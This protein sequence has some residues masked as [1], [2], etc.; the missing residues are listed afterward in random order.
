MGGGQDADVMLREGADLAEGRVHAGAGDLGAVGGRGVQ[1]RAE[2]LRGLRGVQPAVPRRGVD[3]SRLAV[4]AEA[5]DVVDPPLDEVAARE[6]VDL[7]ERVVAP[8]R[9]VLHF[10]IVA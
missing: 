10:S 2:V 1:A 8:L 9:V 7:Q 5:V 4:N 3:A 6:P